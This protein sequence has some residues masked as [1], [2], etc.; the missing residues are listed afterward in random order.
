[1]DCTGSVASSVDWTDLGHA[2]DCTGTGAAEEGKDEEEEGDMGAG[3]SEL[4]ETE[5]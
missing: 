5:G 1:M 3:G 4:T 2:V